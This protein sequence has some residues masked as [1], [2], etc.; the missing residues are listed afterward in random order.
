VKDESSSLSGASEIGIDPELPTAAE[1]EKAEWSEAVLATH[2]PSAALRAPSAA[3]RRRM[4]DELAA[5]L[6]AAAAALEGKPSK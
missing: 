2:H 5:D 4:R 6:R 1:Q 3:D